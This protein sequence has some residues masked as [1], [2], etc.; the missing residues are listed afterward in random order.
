MNKLIILVAVMSISDGMLA[1]VF[2]DSTERVKLSGRV[3]DRKTG[4][5]VEFASVGL[6]GSPLSTVTNLKGEFVFKIPEAL[7][8]DTLLVSSIG[9]KVKRTPVSDFK[10]TDRIIIKLDQSETILAGVVVTDSLNGNEIMKLAL[11]RMKYN[12]PNFP[13]SMNAFYREKQMV[14]GNYVSLIEAAITV[15]D[16]NNI[17]KRKSPLRSKI[18]V[19][20]LRRSLRYEHP[21]ADWWNKENLLLRGWNVNPVPYGYTGLNKAMRLKNYERIGKTVVKGNPTYIV[22]DR[23]SNFWSTEYF[24]QAE[25]YAFVRVEE[26][27]SFSEKESK[28]WKLEHD[29]L[30]I[31]VVVKKRE[32][33]IDFKEYQGKYY[34]NYLKFDSNQDYFHH[35][36]KFFNFRIMQDMII[37]NLEIDS[38]TKIERDEAIR[39]PKSLSS[40]SYDY[41]KEFWE[42]FNIIQETPL[43]SKL[44]ADLETKISLETQFESTTQ[45][46]E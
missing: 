24:V 30:D 35:K 4:N 25:T 34:L 40:K 16:Q 44:I 37:N 28:G 39:I 10:K 13:I 41:D 9:Y 1:Q 21:Y 6:S 5:A 31:D 19:D 20:Q 38:P 15:Y 2:T 23:K 43:E 7:I 42:N 8:T 32:V 27:Y 12:H 18:R 3:M 14:D 45:Q 33:V 46:P 22:R 36:E 11:E 26:H 29:T 17:K